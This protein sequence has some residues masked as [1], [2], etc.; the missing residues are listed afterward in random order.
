[1]QGILVKRDELENSYHLKTPY[2]S[3]VALL[4]DFNQRSTDAR[5]ETTHSC[6]IVLHCNKTRVLC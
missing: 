5:Y 4:L 6:A 3:I 2:R 1:M